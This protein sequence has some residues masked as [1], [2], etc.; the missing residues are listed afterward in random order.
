MRPKAIL[1]GILIAVPSVRALSD[2]S[3]PTKTTNSE[4]AVQQR[5]LCFIAYINDIV[6]AWDGAKPSIEARK[7]DFAV[8]LKNGKVGYIASKTPDREALTYTTVGY[9]EGLTMVKFRDGK[10]ASA[11]FIPG[12]PISGSWHAEDVVVTLYPKP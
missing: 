4:H 11:V 9:V 8:Q 10:L 2:D 5:T 1:V 6:A 3:E 7:T 12:D